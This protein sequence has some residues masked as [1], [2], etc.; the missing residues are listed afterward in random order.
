MY[1]NA[2]L[3]AFDAMEAIEDQEERWREAVDT[4]MQG[5]CDD[6]NALPDRRCAAFRDI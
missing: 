3:Q 5:T 4:R 1:T 6:Y 2:M